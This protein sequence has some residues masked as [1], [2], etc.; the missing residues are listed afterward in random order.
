MPL[1]RHFL[2]PPLFPR[3][4]AAAES[5]FPV[6]QAAV[7]R[8]TRPMPAASL[9]GGRRPRGRRTLKERLPVHSGARNEARRSSYVT[10]IVCEEA[11]AVMLMDSGIRSRTTS[12]VDERAWD[13]RTTCPT[14]CH[15]PVGGTSTDSNTQWPDRPEALYGSPANRAHHRWDDVVLAP[16]PKLPTCRP[17]S[18]GRSG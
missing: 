17:P 8:Q 1:C 14:A 18:T 10:Y 3:C 4:P 9:I 12:A 2:H 11:L 7:C 16:G 13:C 15:S 6:W 5:S